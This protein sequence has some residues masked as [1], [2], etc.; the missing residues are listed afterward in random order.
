MAPKDAQDDLGQYKMPEVLRKR[1]LPPIGWDTRLQQGTR[2]LVNLKQVR[3][4][5]KKIKIWSAWIAD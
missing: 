4:Q 2:R 1:G 3:E 5:I